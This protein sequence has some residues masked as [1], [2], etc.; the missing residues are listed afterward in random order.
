MSI[1][2]LRRL[3]LAIATWLI[4]S[5]IT[6]VI[7]THPAGVETSASGWFNYLIGIFFGNLGTDAYGYDV[8][9]QLFSVF[10]A[11]IELIALAFIASLIIG[12]SF[13]T[14]AGIYSRSWI[15]IGIRAF[16]LAGH[17]IPIFLLGSLFVIYVSPS[18]P[19]IPSAGRYNLLFNIRETT[20]FHIFNLFSVH[21]GDNIALLQNIFTHI[22]LPVITLCLLPTTEIINDVQTEVS[23]IMKKNYIKVAISKGMSHREMIFRHILPNALPSITLHFGVLFSSMIGALVVVESIFD[24]PGIGR[25]LLTAT[26]QENYAAISGCVLIIASFILCISLL[27][28]IIGSV[29]NP[30]IR[31]QW[32]AIV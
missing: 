26:M 27:S 11:S 19:S 7:L 3:I 18:M 1:Y 31:K 10:P 24:W 4:I 12:V 2:I 28:E 30:L 25:W 23:K 8:A 17:A 5:I 32:N 20:G 21:N 29:F 16:M 6:Y 9:K 14:L 15:N 22:F 13:G